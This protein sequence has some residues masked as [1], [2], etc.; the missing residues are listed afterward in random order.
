MQ[1]APSRSGPV[2]HT[3]RESSVLS[4]VVAEGM[5]APWL[6]CSN[7]GSAY[8]LAVPAEGRNGRLL[9]APRD[10]G[11]VLPPRG[12]GHLKFLKVPSLLG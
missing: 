12:L 8:L 6:F 3:Q 5:A 9:I 7:G 4:C 2:S 11:A 10:F 1:G